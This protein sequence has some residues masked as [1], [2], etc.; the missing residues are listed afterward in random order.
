MDVNTMLGAL[1][2]STFSSCT[3]GELVRLRDCSSIPP[4]QL[5]TGDPML[6]GPSS[7]YLEQHQRSASLLP[8]AKESTVATVGLI[9]GETGSTL[10]VSSAESDATIVPGA[11]AYFRPDSQVPWTPQE[12]EALFALMQISRA[13][14]ATPRL[15]TR[16]EN[17]VYTPIMEGDTWESVWRRERIYPT[18]TYL[19][20]VVYAETGQAMRTMMV[21]EA[22]CTHVCTHAHADDHQPEARS[23]SAESAASSQTMQ[24]EV[25][26]GGAENGESTVGSEVATGPRRTTRRRNNRRRSLC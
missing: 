23:A 10:G 2:S 26:P 9:P 7:A 18:G 21:R 4:A 20:R 14:P 24:G 13:V 1:D 19:E 11:E 8:S 17:P 12:F 5:G 25:I 6:E 3:S 22:P 16:A 15:R